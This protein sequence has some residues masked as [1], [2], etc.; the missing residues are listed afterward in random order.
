MIFPGRV[1]TNRFTWALSSS[2]GKYNPVDSKS[3]IWGGLVVTVTEMDISDGTQVK[4]ICG[5]FHHIRWTLEASWRTKGSRADSETALTCLSAL[6]I[7]TSF[8]FLRLNSRS[9]SPSSSSSDSFSSP[10]R[11]IAIDENQNE[12]R[13]RT[14]R[15][16]S[17][18]WLMIK[19]SV[20]TEWQ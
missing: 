12:V 19:Q 6:E 14:N 10:P 13:M 17:Q 11:T 18:K 20:I 5:C 3:D 9:S 8:G 16:R 4:V 7:S 15:K 1:S 2:T